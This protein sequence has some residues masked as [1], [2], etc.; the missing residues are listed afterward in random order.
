MTTENSSIYSDLDECIN[1]LNATT[2]EALE[3][4]GQVEAICK[5]IQ[6]QVENSTDIKHFSVATNVAK[7]SSAG[8]YLACDRAETVN[9]W[10]VDIMET[11]AVLQ[12][13]EES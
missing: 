6:R 4:L 1:A 9:A 13:G 12:K 5:A 7:L 3:A 8:E 10:R 2:K 11:I